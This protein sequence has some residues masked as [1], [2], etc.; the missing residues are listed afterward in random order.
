MIREKLMGLALTDE[1]VQERVVTMANWVK[2]NQYL[3]RQRSDAE[4]LLRFIKTE[5]LTKNRSFII[6][7]LLGRWCD[8]IIRLEKEEFVS[9]A[10]EIIERHLSEKQSR[11]HLEGTG[12]DRREVPL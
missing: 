1:E 9:H 5:M 2:F 7:R 6:N 10:E 3:N 8:K 11:R 12:E 4:E